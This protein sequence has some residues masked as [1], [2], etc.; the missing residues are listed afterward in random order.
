MESTTYQIDRAS[1]WTMRVCGYLLTAMALAAIRAYL[2]TPEKAPLGVATFAMLLFGGLGFYCLRLGH[3]PEAYS[4]QLSREGIRR[5]SSGEWIP[6]S[7]VTGL[8]ERRI[9]QRIDVIGPGGPTG[10]TLEYQLED[11]SKALDEVL[12]RSRIATPHPP[13]SLRRPAFSSARMIAVGTSLGFCAFGAWL[14]VCEH[15]GLAVI[16]AVPALG[17]LILDGLSQRYCR[18]TIAD[19]VLTLRQVSRTT[20]YPVDTITSVRLGLRPIGRGNHLL[21][22]FIEVDGKTIAIRQFDMNPFEIVSALR[23]E[24]ANVAASQGRRTS[25]V[26]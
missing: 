5:A 19:G 16:F 6:W 8:R 4:I 17:L 18:L 24:I 20:G 7:G 14:W 23:E 26:A 2:Y 10:I 11:F 22:V 9:H 25:V 21:D 3:W 15:S 12:A 13:C 1:V